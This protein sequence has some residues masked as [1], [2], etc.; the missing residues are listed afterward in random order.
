MLKKNFI[1][2][3]RGLPPGWYPH[4]CEETRAFIQAC[5]QPKERQAQACV[6]PHA[7]WFFSGELAWE[8]IASLASAQT[9]VILGGHLPPA[10]SLMF[11]DCDA[12]ETPLGN[13]ETDRDFL[14]NLSASLPCRP[15]GSRDNTVEVQLPF[16]KYAFPNA[17]VAGL[18]VPPSEIAVELGRFL[19]GLQKARGENALVVIASTDLTHYGP[20]YEFTPRG[21]GPAA[22]KWAREEN[23]MPFLD[24]LLRMDHKEVLRRGSEDHA[25]CSAGAAAAAAVCAA[26]LGLKGRLE[27]YANSLEKHASSS[28]VGYGVV[29]FS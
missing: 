2:Q 27:H 4:D 13:V 26:E 22:V 3:T 29:S 28:F 7:G 14:K 9:V 1:L 11:Y 16:V 15:D 19:A 12:F 6:V 18:R 24:A 10:G 5:P 8:G 25:A 20:N 21:T 23:D 17:K